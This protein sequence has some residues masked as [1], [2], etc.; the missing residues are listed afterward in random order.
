MPKNKPGRAPEVEGLD[1]VVAADQAVVAGGRAG[2]DQSLDGEFA[3]RA[4]NDEPQLC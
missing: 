2:F 4:A 3:V 1:A